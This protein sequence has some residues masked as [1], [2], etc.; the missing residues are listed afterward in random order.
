MLA[1]LR[2]SW[3]S[4]DGLTIFAPMPR[5]FTSRAA[6]TS[7]LDTLD[8]RWV[9][10]AG[11]KAIVK[12]GSAAARTYAHMLRSEWW[13][14]AELNGFVFDEEWSMFPVPV[15]FRTVEDAEAE[16]ARSR[17][18]L[19]A[20]VNRSRR[21]H[22]SSKSAITA[23]QEEVAELRGLLAAQP[24]S[25]T[26]SD[27]PREGVVSAPVVDDTFA[28]LRAQIAE[29]Q[30]ALAE[31][32]K[33]KSLPV[34]PPTDAVDAPTA[35]APVDTDKCLYPR[36][37]IPFPA[38]KY[39]FNRSNVETIRVG[40]SGEARISVPRL[41]GSI[42][43]LLWPADHVPDWSVIARIELRL[44]HMDRPDTYAGP[45]RRPLVFVLYDL[46]ASLATFW[47]SLEGEYPG[48]ST[49]WEGRMWLRVSRYAACAN[50]G[51]VERVLPI[52]SRSSDMS[53]SS[54]GIQ[55]G[56][57][58]VI[59]GGGG[60]GP[61]NSANEWATLH[62]KYA[63]PFTKR[64]LLGDSGKS[65][66]SVERTGASRDDSDAD[67]FEASLNASI[68]GSEI[69]AARGRVGSPLLCAN[70]AYDDDAQLNFPVASLPAVAAP[71]VPSA[72]STEPVVP[73][74][75]V[76]ASFRAYPSRA[77]VASGLFS[78]V[79]FS[80]LDCL[81]GVGPSVQSTYDKFWDMWIEF[82]TLRG[83]QELYLLKEEDIDPQCAQLLI[84]LFVVYLGRPP[85]S[86]HAAQI[87][88]VCS[89]VRNGFV[90]LGGRVEL[91]ES[92]ML[93]WA[94]QSHAVSGKSA[95]A[96]TDTNKKLAAPAEFY[97]FIK[98][99][100]GDTLAGIMVYLAVV[101][102]YL[103]GVRYCNVGHTSPFTN[104]NTGAREP[105]NKHSLTRGEVFFESDGRRLDVPSFYAHA[106]SFC[107][108]ADFDGIVDMIDAVVFKFESHKIKGKRSLVIF[109]V[110]SGAC[111]H[112]SPAELAEQ[113]YI[114]ELIDWILFKSGHGCEP[115]GANSKAFEP[116]ALV[117]SKIETVV[118]KSGPHV[119][120]AELQ[121]DKSTA[122]IK[123]A[124]E[125]FGLDPAQFSIYSVR[126]G[127]ITELTETRTCSSVD[128]QSFAGHSIG[129]SA[130]G[131]Y[132]LFLDTG[133]RPALTGS[134]FTVQTL[135]RVAEVRAD[136][137]TIVKR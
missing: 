110:F 68:R 117:F 45:N 21:K 4:G 78:A 90:K 116:A 113:T 129:S 25:A 132:Q 39:V 8:A 15:F 63:L 13:N 107:S 29:L 1:A 115:A 130:T 85:H 98:S 94:K 135:K 40:E 10:A 131:R 97:P 75:P 74:L 11:G 72:A 46:R 127:A 24:T 108:K 114:R 6:W 88:T 5:L 80:D 3:G 59:R 103:T 12:P 70:D 31:Q 133:P 109:Q 55:D 123:S 61:M 27:G 47:E 32:V 16:W 81:H 22:R 44:P 96:I 51:V 126:H 53:L 118:R 65:L 100:A 30:A 121:R 26:P 77:A 43:P 105:A 14:T 125:H 67:D 2:P 124:A 64:S 38:G 99:V 76:G 84:G 82:L 83:S 136:S 33:C 128:I 28:A 60:G 71:S 34:A 36:V 89:G 49:H 106:T 23:L 52:R 66:S 7:E 48:I 18:I 50:N 73:K 87:G 69:M 57:V 137:D 95:A 42:D 17:D 92:A 119:Y 101:F 54:A 86:K 104:T 41:P 134:Q 9:G 79:D 19:L 35:S 58:V 62:E 37:A 91:W 120:R 111:G 102:I 56:D 112:L 122:A 93:K 20:S